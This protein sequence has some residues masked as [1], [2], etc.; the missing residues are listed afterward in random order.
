MLVK[1]YKIFIFSCPNRSNG[2]NFIGAFLGIWISAT[3]GYS[4]GKPIFTWKGL[5][6]A[7]LLMLAAYEV[8]KS[9]A[10]QGVVVTSVG[11]AT[12]MFFFIRSRTTNWVPVAVY[13]TALVGMGTTALLGA[14]QKGPLA[15][16]VYKTSVSLRGAY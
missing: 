15:Q 10:V 1:T 3:F 2:E 13:S 8:Y 6:T 4:L 14:L 5:L 16:Y 11:L 12:V 9:H 7:L